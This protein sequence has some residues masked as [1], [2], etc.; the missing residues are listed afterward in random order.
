[1]AG[2]FKEIEGTRSTKTDTG[3]GRKYDAYKTIK[4]NYRH[5]LGEKFSYT[6]RDNKDCQDDAREEMIEIWS[7]EAARR[8]EEIGSRSIKYVC[9]TGN[10]YVTEW[11][12]L[13]SNKTQIAV[14]KRTYGLLDPEKISAENKEAGKEFLLALAEYFQMSLEDFVDA[15]CESFRIDK[16]CVEY[17]L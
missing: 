13:Y 16:E 3:Y 15:C 17:F 11:L 10:S 9:N 4:V 2:K 1:M 8:I 5:P 7:V 12:H 6:H 14:F